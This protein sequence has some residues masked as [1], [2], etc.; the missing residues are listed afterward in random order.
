[1]FGFLPFAI[2]IETKT[3]DASQEEAKIQLGMWAA[4]QF[5]RLRMLVDTNTVLPT[6]P[7]LSVSGPEWYLHFACDRDQQIVRSFSTCLVCQVLTF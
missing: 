6:L 3:L 4:A 1:M 7:L 5:N 2:S